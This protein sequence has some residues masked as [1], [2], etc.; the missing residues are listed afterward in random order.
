MV[1]QS[2]Q[3][4]PYY[5]CIPMP[6]VMSEQVTR[7]LTHQIIAP[8]RQDILKQLGDIF[9]E[10]DSSRWFAM[11][12]TVFVLVNNSERCVKHNRNYA[13]RHRLPVRALYSLL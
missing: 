1:P 4:S 2:D 13:A 5:G 7:I 8:L 6:L 12:L 11:F 9:K 10:K 3:N